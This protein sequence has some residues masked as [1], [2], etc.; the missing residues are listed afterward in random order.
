MYFRKVGCCGSDLARVRPP[1]LDAEG[2][3][4]GLGCGNPQAI[5]A[6]RLGESVLDLGSGA[7]STLRAACIDGCSREAGTNNRKGRAPVGPHAILTRSG[8]HSPLR[9]DCRGQ[10]ARGVRGAAC[11]LCESKRCGRPRRPR[12]RIHRRRER[13]RRERLVFRAGRRALRFPDGAERRSQRRIERRAAAHRGRSLRQ[14]VADVR[15]RLSVQPLR[16]LELL[17]FSGNEVLRSCTR[18]ELHHDRPALRGRPQCPH[19]PLGRD[20]DLH[21]RPVRCPAQRDRPR[22]IRLLESVQPALR[23][24]GFLGDD[25]IVGFIGTDTQLWQ[26]T[27]GNPMAYVAFT[28]SGCASR[29]RYG[30]SPMPDANY[31][32]CLTSAYASRRWDCASTG[33]HFVMSQT[34]RPLGGP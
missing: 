2:A 24:A 8:V 25:R 19:A 31:V 28:D 26:C 33:T 6:L 16:I 17:H 23:F 12:R 22:H 5:A 3:N 14:R 21:A 30:T 32:S 18:P 9:A 20:E 15:P 7:A 1:C 13:R 4:R 29:I 11:I 27:Y 10:C 34:V